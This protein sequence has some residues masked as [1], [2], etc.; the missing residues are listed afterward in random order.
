MKKKL[1]S[2]ILAMSMVMGLAACGNNG[3]VPKLQKAE[4]PAQLLRHQQLQ[5]HPQQ[6]QQTQLQVSTAGSHLQIRLHFA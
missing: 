1:L 3:P 5:R 2:A 6:R 4:I